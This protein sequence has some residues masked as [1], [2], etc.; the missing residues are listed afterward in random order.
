MIADNPMRRDNL[1]KLPLAVWK[2]QV[3]SENWSPLLIWKSQICP[4]C[5][6]PVATRCCCPCTR[7]CPASSSLSPIY[8]LHCFVTFCKP[9]TYLSTS[10]CPA[11]ARSRRRGRERRL[12]HHGFLGN[13]GWVPKMVISKIDSNIEVGS[14][15]GLGGINWIYLDNCLNISETIRSLISYGPQKWLM[16]YLQLSEQITRM[17]KIYFI[18]SRY[19]PI[20]ESTGETNKF[21]RGFLSGTRIF[22]KLRVPIP[23]QPCDRNVKVLKRVVLI[24]VKL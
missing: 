3:V 1:W 23:Y 20:F 8:P 2:E 19:H 14:A 24:Y 4:K 15:G 12:P 5:P 7:V 17:S 13:L 11:K 9:A 21:N 18:K 10:T 16:V 6:C 22:F